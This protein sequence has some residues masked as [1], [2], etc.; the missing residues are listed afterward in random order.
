MY[1]RIFNPPDSASYFIFGPRGTGKTSWLKHRYKDAVYFDLLKNSLFNDLRA[2]PNRLWDIIP[3]SYRGPIIIDEIQ[4]VPA[5]LD[6][7]HS[8]MNEKKTQWQFILTGSNAR[9]LRRTG[10]NLLAGRLRVKN[11]YPLI[12]SELSTDFN[13]KKSVQYGMLP[14]V[15]TSSDPAE[16]LEGYLQVYVDQEVRLEGLV[17]NIEDFSRFLEAASLSQG[18]ILNISNV[19]SDCSVPRKTVQTYFEIL[20]DLLL[21]YRIPVFQ[22]KSKRELIKHNKF[23]FFDCGLFQ[24]IRP[25][26]I[27]DAD[28]EINGAA[29]ETLVLSH[30]KAVNDLCSLKYDLFFWHT[31]N[32]LEVDFILYGE[33][34]LIAIEVKSSSSIR[35]GDLHGLQ[36]FKEDYP[37]AKL[38]FIYG[39]TNQT[40]GDITVINAEDFLVNMKEYLS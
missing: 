8:Q 40:Q 5:L 7:I 34:G 29:L 14:E 3:K 11:F 19:S 32:H 22:K 39:G 16:F 9:K 12:A 24:T 4:K 21:A 2:K 27:L 6:E 33:K 38:L 13:L 15:W 1:T 28:S 18:S 36:C 31:K 10:V 30:L 26:G 37:R 17:R 35:E 20:E 25:K 23:Y